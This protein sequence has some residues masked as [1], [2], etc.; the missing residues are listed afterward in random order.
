MKGLKEN[1]NGVVISL[2]EIFVGILLLVNPIGFTSGIVIGSGIILCLYGIFSVFKYFGTHI[3]EAV[4]HQDLSIGLLAI[5]GGVFCIFQSEWFASAQEI[6]TIIYGVFMIVSGIGKIQWSIDLLRL[7]RKWIVS[8]VSAILSVIFGFVILQ[9]P[10]ETV[11]ILWRFT[12]VI[13]IVEAV[14]DIASLI[15]VAKNTMKAPDANVVPAA[16]IEEK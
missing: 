8:G 9:N 3:E 15:Y 6:L 4:I 7:K 12:G 13:M 10:F 1:R 2:L 16:E 5:L 14:I 11:E